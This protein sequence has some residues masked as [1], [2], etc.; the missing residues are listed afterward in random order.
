MYSHKQVGSTI[1]IALAAGAVSIF[2]LVPPI[3]SAIALPILLVVGVVFGS[4]SISVEYNSLRWHFGPG[5]FRQEIALSEIDDVNRIRNKWYYGW[6]V[7][8]VPHGILYNVSGLSAVQVVLRSGKR[9]C[10]GTDEPTKLEA[11]IRRGADLASGS[12]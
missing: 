12:G 1:I 11:A 8:I 9:I 2:F 4:L 6:G 10:L 7:R 3:G 5:I